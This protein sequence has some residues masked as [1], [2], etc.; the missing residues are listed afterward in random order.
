[1][2][3]S[4]DL[5]SFSDL[6]FPIECHSESKRKELIAVFFEELHEGGELALTSYTFVA[7]LFIESKLWSQPRCPSAGE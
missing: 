7:A 3:P 5:H 4:V 2:H 6:Q 1:M